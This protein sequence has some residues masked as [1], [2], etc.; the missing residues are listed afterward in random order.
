MGAQNELA[1]PN[2]TTSGAQ[3]D[4]AEIK[5]DCSSVDREKRGEEGGAG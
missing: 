3:T 2:T 5:S 1:A 4:G